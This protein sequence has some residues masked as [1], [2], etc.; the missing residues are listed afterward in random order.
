[1]LVEISAKDITTT[2][3]HKRLS[4]GEIVTHIA[5]RNGFALMKLPTREEFMCIAQ[6]TTTITNEAGDSHTMC[7]GW[8]VNSVVFNFFTTNEIVRTL[9]SAF[10]VD[11]IVNAGTIHSLNKTMKRYQRTNSNTLAIGEWYW[12]DNVY[13]TFN[14]FFRV[15]VDAPT[16]VPVGATIDDMQ[17]K[18]LDCVNAGQDIIMLKDSWDR[19]STPEESHIITKAKSHTAFAI[20]W[21]K[22]AI[23]FFKQPTSLFCASNICVEITDKKKTPTPVDYRDIAKWLIER[24]PDIIK[25]KVTARILDDPNQE[26]EQQNIYPLNNE[27][28]HSVCLVGDVIEDGNNRVDVFR[29]TIL[30]PQAKRRTQHGAGNQENTETNHKGGKRLNIEHSNRPRRRKEKK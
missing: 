30:P 17:E 20:T 15:D 21:G 22:N 14:T 24:S 3:Q 19:E 8:G 28:I 12:M 11:T 4:L 9:F 7:K 10:V 1:M 23:F 27:F 6:K 13:E 29:D 18:V 2:I 26:T 16:N 25:T 5:Y